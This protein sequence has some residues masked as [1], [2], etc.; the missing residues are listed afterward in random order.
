VQR[1]W[2]E[3]RLKWIWTWAKVE[4]GLGLDLNRAWNSVSVKMG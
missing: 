1:G 2:D 4:L 3:D